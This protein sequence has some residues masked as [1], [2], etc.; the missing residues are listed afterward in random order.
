MA[1]RL[2]C[3]TCGETVEPALCP[4]CGS[5]LPIADRL[6]D[7]TA[8]E[9]DQTLSERDQSASDLD[10]TW[11]DLDQSASDSDQRTADEDR[12]AA[13]ADFSGGGSFMSHERGVRARSRTAMDRAEVSTLRDESAAVRLEDSS[14]RDR[15]ADDRDERTTARENA[16]AM[17]TEGTASES[18]E[19][20]LTRTRQDRARAAADRAKAAEDRARAAADREQAS[21]ERAKAHKNRS[22]SEHNLKLSTTDGLTGVWTRQFGLQEI[23]R[24]LERAQ[25]TGGA[26]T[27][28]FVDVDDLKSVNDSRGHLAGDG[29]LRLVGEALRANVRLYDVVVRYGGDEFLCAMPNLSAA[30]VR[31]RLDAIAA[32]VG[33]HEPGNSISFGL[34]E[35]QPADNLNDLIGRADAA[36]LEAKR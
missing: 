4:S 12:D 18:L 7:L 10:Q 2:I 6:D 34:A 8:A 33:K 21:I 1:S 32:T 25:R 23:S 29:L 26:L 5:E 27:M 36:L 9:R 30:Q 11:A 16:L 15:V 17:A 22:E 14:R 31:G 13:E 28:A 24:E 3:P 20:A 19:D 35:A